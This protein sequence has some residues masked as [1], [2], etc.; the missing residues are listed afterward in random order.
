[1]STDRFLVTGA[2]GCIGAWTIRALREEGVDVIA[3]NRSL[4][5]DRLRLV[6]ERDDLSDVVFEQ[7]DI[8]D[9][10]ALD[11]VFETHEP[12][13]V[14]HLAALQIPFCRADPSRGAQV[15]VQGHINIFEAVRARKEKI[16][17]LVYSGSVAMYSPADSDAVRADEDAL[18]HPLTHYGVYKLDNEGAGRVYW[19]EHGMSSIGL[20]PM[21]VFGAG[22]DQGMT[23]A[24]TLAMRAAISGESHVIPHS[25]SLFL[26]YAPDVA[27]AFVAAARAGAKGALTFNV[28]GAVVSTEDVVAAIRANVAD[29]QITI[30]GDALPF[31]Y[32][33]R[34]DG[35]NTLP[36]DFS[37][38]PFETAVHETLEH[39]RRAGANVLAST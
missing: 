18:P 39:F 36:G 29:A 32:D 33:V 17:G 38:T 5:L 12:T 6:I 1:M 26:N 24:S 35:I 21:V 31:P 37:V 23:S 20:R 14:I 3:V 9:K 22:R 30:E 16:Q 28:P 34:A 4:G 13:H 7:C 15:N 2:L 8:T 10:A 27:R 25:G 11:R 19:H